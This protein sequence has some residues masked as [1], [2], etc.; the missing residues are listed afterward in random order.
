MEDS[1]FWVG[2]SNILDT[3]ATQELGG[4]GQWVNESHIFISQSQITSSS[5]SSS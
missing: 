5:S 3:K 4:N 1:G 2:S